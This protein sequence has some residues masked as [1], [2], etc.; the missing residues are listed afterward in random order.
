VENAR[1]K[2]ARKGLDLIVVND[3]SDQRIGFDSDDNE[4]TLIAGDT[5]ETVPR[6]N[7]RVVS[8]VIIERI[9]DLYERRSSAR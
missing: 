1:D 3:V 8:R 6:A 5:E 2:L 4:V 7:K 9:A